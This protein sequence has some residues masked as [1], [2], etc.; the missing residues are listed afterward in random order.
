MARRA[1][2]AMVVVL[3]ALVS[4]CGGGSPLDPLDPLETHDLAITTTEDTPI[5]FVVPANVAASF[6]IAT[7]PSH[8]TLASADGDRWTYTPARD[9]GGADLAVIGVSDA[10]STAMAKV[11]ITVAPIDDAPV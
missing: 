4:A 7:A 3:G 9:F 8:G 5:D 6:A 11:A 2:A 10:R 1:A